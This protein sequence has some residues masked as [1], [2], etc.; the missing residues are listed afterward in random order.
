MVGTELGFKL[1]LAIKYLSISMFVWFI[2]P[3]LG[4]ITLQIDTVGLLSPNIKA[5][6]GDI[7][8]IL[9][10]LVPFLLAVKYIY[11]IRKA[12]NNLEKK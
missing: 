7:Q 10:V 4:L 8:I 2:K 3:I 9:S 11:D 12:K 1:L 5:Y 6:M